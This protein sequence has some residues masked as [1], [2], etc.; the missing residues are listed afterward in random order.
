[1]YPG[2]VVALLMEQATFIK[3]CSTCNDVAVRPSVLI[4]VKL[5]NGKN[6]KARIALM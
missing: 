6:N 2:K 5:D 4:T 3:G 1:M